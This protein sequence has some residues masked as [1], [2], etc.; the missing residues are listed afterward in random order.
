MVLT[1][2]FLPTTVRRQAQFSPNYYESVG[3][4]RAVLASLNRAVSLDGIVNDFLVDHVAHNH[5]ASLASA[6]PRP[7]V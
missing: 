4:R 1:E 6:T 2:G 5:G 3:E 7:R